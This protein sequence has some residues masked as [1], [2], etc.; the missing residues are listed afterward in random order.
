MKKNNDKSKEKDQKY[1]FI[2]RK[3][4]LLNINQRTKTKNITSSL[5]KS[6]LKSCY[7]S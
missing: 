1:S 2:D 6:P 4:S 3:H 5:E 7:Q